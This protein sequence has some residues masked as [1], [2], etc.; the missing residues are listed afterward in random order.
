RHALSDDVGAGEVL[1]RIFLGGLE[2]Q[3]N[4]L[5]VH[6]DVEDV[7]GDLVADG[8]DLTRVVDVL[9]GQFGDVD[10]RID[11]TEVD[12]GTEVDDGGHDAGTD[13]AL[14]Q[15]LQEG[16]TDRRLSL[17]EPGAAGQDH[18]VAVLVELDDLGLDLLAD[19]GGEVA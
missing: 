4:A 6:V 13:L 8:D 3:R 7:D 15:G 1:P 11:T 10:E 9:P 2:R 12:E 14:L 19:V 18:I 5:T 17:L 16:V